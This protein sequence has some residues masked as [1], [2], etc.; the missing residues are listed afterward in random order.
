MRR[1]LS[2]LFGVFLILAGAGV[3]LMTVVTVF[4]LPPR[5]AS[6]ARISAGVTDPTA[7]ATEIEKI[8]SQPILQ[9][10]VTNLDL[11]KAWGEKHKEAELPLG[12]ASLM[13]KKDLAVSRSRDTHLIEIKV[14]SDSPDEA[15]LIANRIAEVYRDSAIAQKGSDGKSSIQIIDK[16]EPN[17]RP[18]RPNKPRA[19]GIGCA[20][21]AVLAIIGIWLVVGAIRRGKQA[22]PR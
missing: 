15:F 9:Q 4:I 5:F 11:A 7:V 13:L 17:P 14:E 10:V 19:I 12:I 1:V 20:V 8:Q 21:G 16:A 3:A 22:A 18:V 2:L 6:T